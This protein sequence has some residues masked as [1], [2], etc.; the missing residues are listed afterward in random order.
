MNK[1]LSSGVIVLAAIVFISGVRR[2]GSAEKISPGIPRSLPGSL[3]D[4]YPPKAKGPM[5]FLAMH[6]MATPLSGLVSDFQ[7]NDLDNALKGYEKFREQYTRVSTLVPEWENEYPSAPVEALGAALKSG[8]RMQF[9]EA[10]EYVG[11]TCHGCHVWSMPATQFKYQWADFKD[12]S[13]TDPVSDRNVSF[14]VF[15]QMIESDLS[16][17]GI[18]LSQNQIPEAREHAQG[19]KSRFRG[20]KESCAICHETERKYYVDE[21]ITAMLN[22]LET[23]LDSEDIDPK[24]VGDILQGIGM[25]SCYKCHLV[26]IPAA[27]SKYGA[28]L[29]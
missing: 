13:A 10:V 21:H 25:E 11:K 23:I 29:E 12:V 26:H 5:Y 8:N 19:L 7:E 27:Y 9:M 6:D 17:I 20:L 14:A 4:F 16:G 1:V 28:K 15:M 18:D 3:D 22:K 24:S 2:D